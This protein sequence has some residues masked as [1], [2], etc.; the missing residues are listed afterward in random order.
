MNPI[1]HASTNAVLQ[2]PPGT[3]PDQVQPLPITRVVFES[4][5]PAVWSYWQPSDE[6]RSAIAAGAAVRLSIWGHTHPPLNLGVD[7]EHQVPEVSPPK[8]SRPY[9]QA[10]EALR[11]G[12]NELPRFS[13]LLDDGGGVARVPDRTG[14]WIHWQSAHELFDAEMV[15]ALI[16][17]MLTSAAIAKATGAQE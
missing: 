3:T 10:V 12:L 8:E 7:E 1:K 14:H 5:I 6:E 17:R 11:R 15:E 4:G 13:F 9:D 2:P 16:A